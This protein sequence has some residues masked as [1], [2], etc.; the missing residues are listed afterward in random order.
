MSSVSGRLSLTTDTDPKTKAF[1]PLSIITSTYF[2]V[3]KFNHVASR[4]CSEEELCIFTLL[5]VSQTFSC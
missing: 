1:S 3:Q 2:K 5:W 4:S